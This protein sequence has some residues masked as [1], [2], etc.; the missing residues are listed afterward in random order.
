MKE[1]ERGGKGKKRR[2]LEELKRRKG[3]LAY[4]DVLWVHN[5]PL[6]LSNIMKETERGGIK[7]KTGEKAEKVSVTH[8]I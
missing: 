2:R 5:I 6:E 3:A 7:E 1:K 4:A 8:F